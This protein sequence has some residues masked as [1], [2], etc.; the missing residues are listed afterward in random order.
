MPCM[1]VPYAISV[2]NMSGHLQRNF[3]KMFTRFNPKNQSHI[4]YYDLNFYV[5]YSRIFTK[6]YNKKHKSQQNISFFY[7][8]AL[9]LLP[10]GH[11]SNFKKK[12]QQGNSTM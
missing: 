12:H 11:F 2:L 6:S 9:K 4:T 7:S 5:P 10:N 3:Q 8:V 1:W